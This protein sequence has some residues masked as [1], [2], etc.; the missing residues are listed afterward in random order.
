M[1]VTCADLDGKELCPTQSYQDWVTGFSNWSDL[2]IFIFDLRWNGSTPL[3]DGVQFGGCLPYLPSQCDLAKLTI[4]NAIYWDLRSTS[5]PRPFFLYHSTF[6]NFVVVVVVAALFV[7][8]LLNIFSM[9]NLPR[10]SEIAWQNFR[11]ITSKQLSSCQRQ[12]SNTVKHN[13]SN[14]FFDCSD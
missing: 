10:A 3:K 1:P 13:T 7:F 14:I 8:L 9:C 6:V 12:F 4:N 11:I 5:S 2:G